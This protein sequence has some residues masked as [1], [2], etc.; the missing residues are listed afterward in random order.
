MKRIKR[1]LNLTTYAILIGMI[2]LVL[3]HFIGGFR[4]VVIK[5]GSM[6][7]TINTG[8]VVVARK[9]EFEDIQKG[10][11]LVFRRGE[12]TVTH[13]CVDINTEARTVT[14]KGDANE[15]PD[16]GQLPASQIIG[17][18]LF[19]LSRGYWILLPII[20]FLTIADFLVDKFSKKD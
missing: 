5:S 2:T 19:H 18:E 10:D 7:P 16:F 6:A 11:I 14:T 20:P 4:Y 9:A 1:V 17:K 12:Y 8:D 13:R 15:D 3:L